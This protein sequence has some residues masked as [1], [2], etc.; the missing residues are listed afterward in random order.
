MKIINKKSKIVECLKHDWSYFLNF[1]LFF[2]VA[3][4]CFF[5]VGFSV[6]LICIFGMLFN[7]F[8]LFR[9]TKKKLY[10]KEDFVPNQSEKAAIMTD[11]EDELKRREKEKHFINN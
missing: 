9:I 7:V 10:G 5:T 1:A 6:F 3:L 2:L 8:S 4:I 11:L